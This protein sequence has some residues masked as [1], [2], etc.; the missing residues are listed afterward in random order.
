MIEIIHHTFTV[1]GF[2]PFTC[3]INCN[4][5]HFGVYVIRGQRGIGAR[6]AGS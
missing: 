5:D 2:L 4:L 1:L 3:D 6:K